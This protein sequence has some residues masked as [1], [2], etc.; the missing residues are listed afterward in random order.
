MQT[1]LAGSHLSCL[2]H[3]QERDQFEA[4]FAVATESL[5]V[6]HP[7]GCFDLTVGM[8]IYD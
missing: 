7:L 5:T 6:D 8:S 2:P 4:S 3:T 1:D